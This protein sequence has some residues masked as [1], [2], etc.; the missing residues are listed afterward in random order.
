VNATFDKKKKSEQS[1]KKP[2]KQVLCTNRFFTAKI[3]TLKFPSQ[4]EISRNP[5]NLEM[6]I[7]GDSRTLAVVF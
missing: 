1:T 4:P 5:V 6:L 2:K 3:P 7:S